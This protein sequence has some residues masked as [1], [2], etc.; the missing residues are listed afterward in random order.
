MRALWLPDALRKWGLDPILVDGWETRGKPLWDVQV[1]VGHHT[2]GPSTGAY[3]SL[4]VVRDGRRAT[5]STPALPGPLSQVG[6][7][8]DCRPRVIASGKANHAGKGAWA[9]ISDSARTLGIEAENDGRQPWP[10]DQV[11]AYQ[12]TV[13]ALLDGAGMAGA[14]GAPLPATRFCGHRE[15]ALPKG[16]KPDPHTLDLDAFRTAVHRLLTGGGG[17]GD[18]DQEA[19]DVPAPTD[20]VAVV[21]AGPLGIDARGHYKLRADGLVEVHGGVDYGDYPRLKPEHRRGTRY[22]VDMIVD[23]EGYTIYANDGRGYRFDPAA[24]VFLVG[25][26]P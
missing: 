11:E 5:A 9:G 4:A 3:P 22:F 15:W 1:I 10:S 17:G 8:R 24:R 21:P 19:L 12:R 26:K 18:T 23:A 20:I 6:L 14:G 16:R 2:A 25:G 13:A 7:G